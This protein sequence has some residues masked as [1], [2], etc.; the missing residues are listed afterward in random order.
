MLQRCNNFVTEDSIEICCESTN[1]IRPFDVSLVE[2]FVSSFQSYAQSRVG[3]VEAPKI[4]V[5]S[6]D[7]E[8]KKR[9]RRK[10][11]EVRFE[12]YEKI[13]ERVES[14]EFVTVWND[15]SELFIFYFYL[16][17]FSQFSPYDIV[18]RKVWV[19]RDP[20]WSAKDAEELSTIFF[21]KIR[22]L[23]IK[24]WTYLIMIIQIDQLE[25]LRKKCLTIITNNC[26]TKAKIYLKAQNYEVLD[27][28]K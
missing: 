17:L 12:N 28:N 22:S 15:T 11:E 23:M 7:K 27:E 18:C 26:E 3:S 10:C 14:W 24:R 8:V 19:V 2:H 13:W 16:P 1:F 20:S 21:R 5:E 4:M 6:L 25:N 9:R